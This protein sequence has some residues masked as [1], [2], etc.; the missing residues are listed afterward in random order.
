[1]AMTSDMQTVA[2]LEAILDGLRGRKTAAGAL[3]ASAQQVQRELAFDASQNDVTA[4]RSLKKAD[5]DA[6]LAHAELARVEGA[7]VEA[8]RRFG[9]AREREASALIEARKLEF[10][11]AGDRL[12]KQNEKLLSALATLRKE[13]DK[14]AELVA[15]LLSIDQE[16]R[17]LSLVAR[18]SLA[19][20]DPMTDALALGLGDHLGRHVNRHAAPTNAAVLFREHDLRSLG[21]TIPDRERTPI[22]RALEGLNRPRPV[23]WSKKAGTIVA[24]G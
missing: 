18:S 6:Q 22:E 17:Q 4:L 24:V 8:R 13:L 1:M 5:A 10:I 19:S 16:T 7:E 21:R 23:S 2:Q 20:T 15:E 3:L 9:A 12:L 11:E 14:R